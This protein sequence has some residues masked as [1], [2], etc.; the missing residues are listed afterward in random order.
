MLVGD[1]F[2]VKLPRERVAAL[3]ASGEGGPFDGSRGRPMKEW[4]TVLDDDAWE[5]LAEESLRFVGER[6]R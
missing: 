3:I 6:R 2:V 1:R 4:L 5:R